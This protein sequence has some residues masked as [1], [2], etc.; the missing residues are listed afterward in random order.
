MLFFRNI[1]QHSYCAACAA[2]NSTIHTTPSGSQILKKRCSIQTPN[3]ERVLGG[4]G[5]NHPIH[6]WIQA[7]VVYAPLVP[8][9]A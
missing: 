6:T 8:N 2:L 5:G 9:E 4:G 3:V 1:S 7:P